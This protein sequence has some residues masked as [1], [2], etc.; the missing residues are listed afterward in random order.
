MKRRLRPPKAEYLE[1]LAPFE[2]R[3]AKLALAV[4]AL[5]LDEGPDATE[6]IYDAYN[7][8]ATGYSFTGRPSD[9]FVHIAVYARWVNL[10][11]HRGSELDDPAGVLQGAGR[12]VRHIRIAEPADLQKP[13]VRAFVK[14]AVARA[15]SRSR[16]GQERKQKC[17]AR[18]LSKETAANAIVRDLHA[19]SLYLSWYSTQACVNAR[20]SSS[21]PLG[22]R[23]R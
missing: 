16:D 6:L 7:A 5:V 19:Q 8:V 18:N 21:R 12:L 20:P 4:R 22:T 15:A 2:S 9:A 17:G 14:A 13:G 11:F 10:G 23:S 3:V 1:F